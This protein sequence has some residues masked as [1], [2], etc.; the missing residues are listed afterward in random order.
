[1]NQDEFGF[2]VRQV[3]ND[4]AER[5]DYRT[6]L[7]LEQARAQALARQRRAGPATV[8]LPALQLAAAGAAP[9]RD[10][11]RWTWLRGA[12]W[13]APLLA[14]AIGFVAIGDWQQDLEIK[15]RAALDFA[16]LL[17]EGPLEAYADRVFGVLLQDERQAAR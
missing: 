3:L 10:G 1:M 7:R 12:G 14:V 4:G 8:R 16:V 17:D 2:R 9:V 15:R 13:A 5:L 11:G 6:V